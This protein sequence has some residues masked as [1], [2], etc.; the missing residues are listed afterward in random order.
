[1]ACDRCCD[2]TLSPEPSTKRAKSLSSLQH[3]S[4]AGLPALRQLRVAVLEV[5]AGANANAKRDG[6]NCEQLIM[7]AGRD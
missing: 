6:R 5:E 7:K 3:E 2:P 4:A 1:M